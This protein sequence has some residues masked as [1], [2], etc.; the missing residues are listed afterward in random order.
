MTE[1]LFADRDTRERIY[2][3]ARAMAHGN[4]IA[5][6]CGV[7]GQRMH[8]DTFNG[9]W[10]CYADY[11]GDNHGGYQTEDQVTHLLYAEEMASQGYSI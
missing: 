7:C 11:R 10:C 1:P 2:N 3:Q 8:K 6:K 9:M 5:P 4:R